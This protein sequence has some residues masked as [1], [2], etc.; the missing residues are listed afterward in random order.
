MDEIMDTK[1]V[2]M[3]FDNSQFRAG[4]EDTIK[5]LDKLDKSLQLQGASDGLDAVTRASKDVTKGM[6][7]MSESVQ[8]VQV[9]FSYLEVAGITAMVRLTNAALT[10]GKRIANNLWSKSIGQVISGGKKRSQNIANAKFQLEG[11]G[12]AWKDIEADINYG[13]QDTAYGLDEAAMAASQLVASQVQLGEEMQTALRGISGTAAMTNS[14]FS[15]ISN[16]WTTVASNG[17]LMTMQLRQLSARGL[18]ASAVLAKAMGTTEAAINQMVT[19]GKISFK[20]FA[21][22]MD[23]AFG[24]HAKEANKTFQGAMS[25]MNA[26]LSR[27]GQKFADP[28]FENLRKI[29]I[30]L[31][32]DIDNINRALQPAVDLFTRIGDKVT[33]V[34]NHILR[35]EHFAKT[36]TALA[37]DVYSYI[38]VVVAAIQEMLPVGTNITG[39]LKSMEAGAKSLQ[40]YGD[41]AE[42][43]KD[44]IK[45]VISV[46]DIFIHG[47]KSALIIL[48]PFGEALLEGIGIP[49]S[50]IKE[51][52]KP[53]FIYE[54]R[55]ALKSIMDVIAK[56]VALKLEGLLKSIA[57]AIKA[58]DWSA[59]LAALVVFINSIPKAVNFIARF[60]Y[61]TKSFFGSIFDA[62]YAIGMAI[63][64][65]IYI[66][67]TALGDFINTVAQAWNG[68]MILFGPKAQAALSVYSPVVSI[69][70]DTS[71]VDQSASQTMSV[72]DTVTESANEATESVQE[73]NEAV[74]ETSERF[75]IAEKNAGRAGEKIGE[76][77][78]EA[79]ETA[80]ESAD[81]IENANARIVTPV[82][83]ISGEELTNERTRPTRADRGDA[84][85]QLAGVQATVGGFNGVLD[86]LKN[87]TSG[88]KATASALDIWFGGIADTIQSVCDS[89]FAKLALFGMKIGPIVA[90]LAVFAVK[91][92]WSLAMFKVIASVVKS[93]VDV[94]KG[95]ADAVKSL[96]LYAKALYKSAVAKEMEAIAAMLKSLA[97]VF[98]ALSVTI[99]VM[100]GAAYVIDRFGLEDTFKLM[101]DG[102]SLILGIIVAFMVLYNMLT[103]VSRITNML[104]AAQSFVA[105]LQ[106]FFNKTAS[107]MKRPKDTITSV[108][109]E[110]ALMCF[111]LV[112]ALGTLIAGVVLIGRMPFWEI[113]KGIGALFALSTM[114]VGFIILLV[115]VGTKLTTYTY[116]YEQA[117]ISKALKGRERGIE[118][119]GTAIHN[120]LMAFAG[121][122]AVMV[123]ATVIFGKMKPEELKQGFG[124]VIISM[125]LLTIFLTAM[126]K[127]TQDVTDKSSAWT[128]SNKKLEKTSKNIT[129]STNANALGTL[130]KIITAIAGYMWAVSRAI[131]AMKGMSPAQLGVATGLLTVVMGGLTGLMAV[132]SYNARQNQNTD[133]KELNKAYS[134]IAKVI[135][136]VSVYML[137]ISAS[138]MMLGT[139]DSTQLAHSMGAL[140]IALILLGGFMTVIPGLIK[141]FELSKEFQ[142]LANGMLAISGSLAI[143]MLATS[144]MFTILQDIDW[145]AM[146]GSAKYLL[147]MAAVIAGM[148]VIIGLLTVIAGDN[149]KT[150]VAASVGVFLSMSVMMLAL[151]KLFEVMDGV[152]W[153]AVSKAFPVVVALG[154]FFTLMGVLAVIIGN[155]G[156]AAGIALGTLAL[157]SGLILAIGGMFYLIGDGMEKIAEAHLKISKAIDA[158][159]EAPWNKAEAVGEG[160]KTLMQSFAEACSYIDLSVFAGALVFSLFVTL[161]ASAIKTLEGIDPSTVN[162][163]GKAINNFVS[164]MAE[165]LESKKAVMQLL[166]DLS[167]LF[168]MIASA[169]ASSAI[170]L[171]VGGL[172]LVAFAGEMLIFSQ[173]MSAVGEQIPPSV[174]LLVTAITSCSSIIFNSG[175]ELLAGFAALFAVGTL[176]IAVGTLLTLGGALM[177][178]GAGTMF[179]ASTVLYSAIESIIAAIS[180][181]GVAILQ[182]ATD[183]MVGVHMLSALAVVM[184]AVGALLIVSGTTFTIGAALTLAGAVILKK[185]VDAFGQASVGATVYAAA[186]IHG[187]NMILEGATELVYNLTNL[188][189]AMQYAGEMT[190]LGFIEGLQRGAALTFASVTAF[191]QNIISVFNGELGIASPATEFIKSAF[192]SVYGYIEGLTQNTPALQD[193]CTNIVDGILSIFNGGAEGMGAAGEQGGINFGNGL[194]GI[195]Q[196]IAPELENMMENLGL[197]SGEVF[198]TSFVNTAK[199]KIQALVD[200]YGYHSTIWNADVAAAAE[201]R[202]PGLAMT[203]A[204]IAASQARNPEAWGYTPPPA[205]A[206]RVDLGYIDPDQYARLF[207]YA[208]SSGGGNGVT[209][210]LASA[211]S[212]S[213]GAG[214]G[215]NDQSKAASIGGGIGNTI[216][217]SNNTYNFY[218]NNYSPEP[219]NRSAIYQQ[220]RQQLNGFYTYVK[221]KNLSY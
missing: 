216:T 144:V 66:A 73:L 205:E 68:L 145:G 139:L 170:I 127:V 141:G 30:S 91:I 10:Y 174:Q 48:R 196:Q 32:Y 62:V 220:T 61:V 161:M 177:A 209:S 52:F 65:V 198:G 189:E 2:Q 148:M 190:T 185:A 37:V 121:V 7:S 56:F 133:D 200:E 192:W 163:V 130:P 60:V 112:A 54:H 42:A 115:N 142:T 194:N 154:V 158:I 1:V 88:Q 214:S 134:G 213:S 33:T 136:A 86:G 46:I 93:A 24:E 143:L 186:T 221:E 47:I 180:D 119:S 108:V 157:I 202:Q 204:D 35:N 94:V 9:A 188:G 11:L 151:S 131:K 187:F 129:G 85:Q 203:A 18:N 150:V 96:S 167:I 3:K 114:L 59:V 219:L 77:Y 29:F 211:I 84:Q 27:I 215:I 58:I 49:L 206:N 67:K 102:I 80:E 75:G 98:V 166:T 81:R 72:V 106:L 90:V 21:E 156:P 13:V 124:T 162:H 5:Q 25:N 36:L 31:K 176:S 153:D 165:D 212:G 41:K 95:I 181:S 71:A 100:V 17:K 175:L 183:L 117:G 104:R 126:I 184:T 111:A 207:N 123:A 138:L 64:G 101:V 82:K 105:Q 168:P 20:E 12:V 195:I 97:A 4:V 137:A 132:I 78:E 14:S 122:L 128:S 40:L 34:I 193:T 55:E 210:D 116:A 23:D 63:T 16:I 107:T 76:T 6:N 70:A 118:R 218:Q 92:A 99:A 140:L 201:A 53:G 38:R 159:L 15:E 172:G 135:A 160:L 152:N 39:I 171:A 146:K 45:D 87:D 26:A 155:M 208:P 109:H 120:V 179:L 103:N 113:A 217:N 173:I 50:K 83:G 110:L 149:A 8:T 164:T 178:L 197:N 169:I 44:A 191:G 69:G 125:I 57:N 79:A 22:A 19:Q 28:V 147:G 199:E 51:N 182:H 43:V 74:T 89:W